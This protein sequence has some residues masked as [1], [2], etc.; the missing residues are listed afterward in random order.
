MNQEKY[1]QLRE[2]LIESTKWPGLYMFK[3]IIPNKNE[4]LEA[5]KAV[6]PK[7]TKFTFKTSRDIRFIS[8]TVKIRMQNAD[9]V[10]AIYEQTKRIDGLLAL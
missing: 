8:I 2:K 3:F 1:N 4:K 6:F 7:G 10:I 5:V 9:A